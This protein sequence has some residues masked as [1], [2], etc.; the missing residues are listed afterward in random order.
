MN[1]SMDS[2][3]GFVIRISE[4]C[5]SIEYRGQINANLSCHYEKLTFYE[6]LVICFEGSIVQGQKFFGV[7][8]YIPRVI[9]ENYDEL[10]LKHMADLENNL[11]D[12]SSIKDVID[13]YI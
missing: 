6:N 2:D 10:M 3:E 12:P 1:N 13:K 11:E 8:N 9:K 5:F 7:V 4:N